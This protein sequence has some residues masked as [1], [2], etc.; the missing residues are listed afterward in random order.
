MLLVFQGHFSSRRMREGA[1]PCPSWGRRNPAWEWLHAASLP[2]RGLCCDA[3]GRPGG[4]SPGSF[5]GVAGFPK[6]ER[7]DEGGSICRG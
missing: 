3:A 6:W 4:S 1:R 5:L 7:K 2:P